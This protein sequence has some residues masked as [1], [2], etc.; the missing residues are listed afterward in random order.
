MHSAKQH[1]FWYR[2]PAC[3][4]NG[5]LPKPDTQY[6]RR[7]K[8]QPKCEKTFLRRPIL[9]RANTLALD[10][11]DLPVTEFRGQARVRGLVVRLK[12]AVA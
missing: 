4:D 6:A 1:Q 11:L 7:L 9:A 8:I 12:L 3:P 2:V 10:R 5:I